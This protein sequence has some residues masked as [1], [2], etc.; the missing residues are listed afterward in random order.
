[1][2]YLIVILN[3][4][5]IGGLFYIVFNGGLLQTTRAI[6][7]SILLVS[8][9]ACDL[10]TWGIL[11]GRIKWKRRNDN[12]LE[13]RSFFRVVY[14]PPKRPWL[15]VADERFQV[16]DISQRGLRF[17]ND[18]NIHLARTI[19]GV[20]T[21]SDGETVRIKGNV[22][23]KKADEISVLLEELIPHTTISK[24]HNHTLPH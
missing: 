20:V 18:K 12:G 8:L 14:A 19:Q 5:L 10:L 7:G 16:A 15:K 24:E 3:L 1:M 22:E 6:L 2:K 4:L 9:C 13:R 21:F 23:W 17:I 11:S